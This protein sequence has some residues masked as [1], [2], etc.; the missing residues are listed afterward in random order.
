MTS[1]Q[2]VYAL[3]GA[4]F[5]AVAGWLFFS[6]STDNGL[7]VALPTVILAIAFAFVGYYL[8]RDSA[9]PRA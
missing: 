9:R 3:L 2:Q 4:L 6:N 1:K 7:L 8:A 5:G